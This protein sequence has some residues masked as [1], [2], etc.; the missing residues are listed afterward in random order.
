[1]WRKFVLRLISPKSSG[2]D[3]A[4]NK[5]GLLYVSTSAIIQII[6]TDI[7]PMVDAWEDQ[8]AFPVHNVFKILGSA[9]FLGVNKP[10]GTTFAN[11]NISLHALHLLPRA[12]RF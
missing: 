10:T 8:K 5:R 11:V 3:V 9:G 6:D 7:N 12:K 1:M 2:P 4:L